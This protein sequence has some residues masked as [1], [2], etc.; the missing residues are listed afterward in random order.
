MKK[1]IKIE[2]LD[3]AHCAANIENRILKLDGVINAKVNFLTEKMIIETADGS[4]DALKE[5]IVKICKDV[6]PDC[7]V[8]F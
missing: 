8:T 3:C 5:E 4:F 7:V 6:E 1:V 2:G